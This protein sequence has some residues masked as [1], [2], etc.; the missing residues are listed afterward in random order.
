MVNLSLACVVRDSVPCAAGV[1]RYREFLLLLSEVHS[2][3]G[4]NEAAQAALS[5]FSSLSTSSPGPPASP[6]HTARSEAESLL[7]L[8]QPARALTLCREAIEDDER[9]RASCG[10]VCDGSRDVG[11][12][13][14]HLLAGRAVLQE[15]ESSRP[16]LME[17]LWG[18]QPHKTQRKAGPRRAARVLGWLSLVPE[19]FCQALSHLLTALQLAHPT[20]PSLLLRQVSHTHIHTHTHTHTMCVTSLCLCRCTSG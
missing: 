10:P 4:D 19:P 3:K 1:H 5:T 2:T 8:R 7:D 9:R 11:V 15:V 14:L 12:A 18:A 13:W 16:V 17:Q 6:L 20:C